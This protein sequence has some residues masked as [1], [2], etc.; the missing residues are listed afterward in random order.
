MYLCVIATTYQSE[1]KEEL[2]TMNLDELSALPTKQ[3]RAWLRKATKEQLTQ[4]RA[5]LQAWKESIKAGVNPAS[6]V[7]S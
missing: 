6:T 5:E 4:V 1:D 2:E 7:G 3:A